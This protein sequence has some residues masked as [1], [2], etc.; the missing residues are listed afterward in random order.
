VLLEPK[1]EPWGLPEMWIKDPDG[2]RIVLVEVPD[3]PPARD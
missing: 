2:G 3:K 1:Q